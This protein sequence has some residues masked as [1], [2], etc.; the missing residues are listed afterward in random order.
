MNDAIDNLPAMTRLRC[1]T[2][3]EKTVGE[4]EVAFFQHL[5]YDERTPPTEREAD[6]MCRTTGVMC[7]VAAT[8]LKLGKA[9]SADHGVWGGR[10]FVD[11]E[12]LHG[13]SGD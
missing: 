10:V 5:D 7:P 9:L 11:G 6:L 4:K 3:Q 8:C 13:E 1:Q 12:E 2:P